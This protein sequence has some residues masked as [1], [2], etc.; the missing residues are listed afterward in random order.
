MATRTIAHEEALERFLVHIAAERGL[1]P[2]TR[3]AYRRDVGQF[4]AFCARQDLDPIT[5]QTQTVRR[6]LANLTTR[7]YARSSVAR[8]AA[9]VRAFY[10]FLVRRK[11][12][13]DNPAALVQTPKRGRA[14]PAII[15]PA[16][17][18][19]LMALPPRDDP[20]GARDRAIL[21]LLYGSGIRVAELVGLDLERIDVDQRVV[22][23]LGKGSKERMVPMSEP[24]AGALRVYLDA[25]PGCMKEASAPEALFFNRRG[26]RM[27]TRDV[28]AMVER[29]VKEAVPGGKASP[30]TFRHTFATH[31]LDGGA[32]LRSV[33]ELLGHIDLRT[34]QVY[35][36]VS[37]EQLRTVYDRAHPRA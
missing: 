10:R 3:E 22:R 2:H 34:T 37:R 16:Q 1:S 15:R 36:H 24:A 30:H 31:L 9:A 13:P 29:Y 21:E 18:E 27:G 26:K 28:R 35:T 7:K 11:L 5:A 20:F 12:R 17:I 32:D 14:L 8:K 25:R 23:V 19:A 6:W 4:F 33:Q